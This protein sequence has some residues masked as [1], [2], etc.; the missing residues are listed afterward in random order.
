MHSHV[1]LLV[2][3]G[4]LLPSPTPT[5]FPP[6]WTASYTHTCISAPPPPHTPFPPMPP[7]LGHTGVFDVCTPAAL[8]NPTTHTF[9]SP[10]LSCPP[11]LQGAP[12][13]LRC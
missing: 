4:L 3:A 5:P 10:P 2:A 6:V 13:G 12:G 7:P 11:P 8:I 1:S 9:T